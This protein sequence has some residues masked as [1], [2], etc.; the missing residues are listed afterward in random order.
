MTELNDLAK[1]YFSNVYQPLM[2][3]EVP[4]KLQFARL[5]NAQFT[6][7]KW[8]FGVKTRTGG[9]AA[10]SSANKSLP[11]A[12]E[13]A[14]DQGEANL[15]RTYTRMA[16]DGLAIEVTKSQ[17]GSYRPA[18]AEVMA[19]RLEAHDL[20][21][22][23]QLLSN[24][25]GVATT[26]SA[27]V[28]SATQSL[29]SDFGLTNGGSGA[30]HIHEGDQVQIYAA[31]RVTL[32]AGGPFTVNSVDHNANSMVLSS[33]VTT[34]TGDLVVKATPDT[35]NLQAGEVNG[36]SV[37]VSANFPGA[38]STFEAIP[39]T[40]S[41]WQAT[42]DSN[43]GTLRPLTDAI[44]LKNITTV[45]SK[46]RKLPNLAVTRPGVTLQYS[47]QFLP[48]RRIQGQD[49]QLVGGYKPVTGIQHA[50][51]V[52][53]VLEDLDCPNSRVFLLN[54]ESFRMADLI[55]TEWFDMDGAQFLRVTDKDAIEGFIRKYW[56]LITIQR[57][58]NAVISDINDY[59]TIDRV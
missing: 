26:I 24:G 28:A 42:V 22:N 55:G 52:I 39:N 40:V 3:S 44:L 20:E 38:G 33:S 17:Q 35:D 49:V 51:G 9:G 57:N 53:P 36:L 12:Q 1:D 56:Q 46:S 34:T 18:L 10:N 13:G 23:R 6:G 11:G 47:E 54:T 32:R 21:V 14:Y 15:V 41:R 4:L 8:I 5:E 59:G 30:R 25:D 48:I 19:D 31:D 16:L 7:R 58:A 2:N 27:G 45:R 50:G 29:G 43:G 37:A